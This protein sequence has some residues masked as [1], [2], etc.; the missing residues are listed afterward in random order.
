MR[1]LVIAG[2][3]VVTTGWAARAEPVPLGDDTMKQTLAG[4]T[5][6]LKTPFGVSIPISFQPNG[7]MSGKAGVLTYFLGAEQDRG[8]WWVSDGK[9]CQK[10]FKWLDAQ[11]N[12]MRLAKEGHTLYWRRDDGMSGT[13]TIE[14]SLPPGADRAPSGLGGPVDAPEPARHAPVTAQASMAASPVSAIVAAASRVRAP[15]PAVTKTAALVPLS[16]HGRPPIEP[17]DS[18]EAEHERPAT[19]AM[20]QVTMPEQDYRWCAAADA[21]SGVSPDLVFVARLGYAD[22]ELLPSASACLTAEPALRHVAKFGL[23]VR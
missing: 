20:S 16:H 2:A 18:R 11:P 13:A 21:G 7:L 10:W 23:D 1:R 14:A 4:K 17:S 12:C 8:R 22:S 6:Q 3:L 9:L 15:T 19:V 5:V